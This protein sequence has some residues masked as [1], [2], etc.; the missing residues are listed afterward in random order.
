MSS[1]SYAVAL[2]RRNLAGVVSKPDQQVSSVTV[3]WATR[4]LFVEAAAVTAAALFLV[5]EDLTATG[6]NP[7]LAAFITGYTSA[8]AVAFIAAAIALAKRKRWSRGPALVL[9]LFL[10]PIGFF[11]IL[12]GLWWLGV[13]LMA[14]GLVVAVLLATP[15]TADALGIK[16]PGQR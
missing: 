2:H 9:N 4:L 12:G 7:Q 15:S 10:L 13:I 8:Y 1:R 3:E 16:P 6:Y 5:Y 14:Y 11:M